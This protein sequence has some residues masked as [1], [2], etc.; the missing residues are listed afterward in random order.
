MTVDYVCGIRNACIAKIDL[1]EDKTIFS[2]PLDSKDINGG[3]DFEETIAYCRIDKRGW[4]CG[5]VTET[6]IQPSFGPTITKE[7]DRNE[8]PISDEEL[9]KI[10]ESDNDKM[11]AFNKFVAQLIKDRIV[12][13]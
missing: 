1:I 2:T 8:A 5:K 9:V 11:N 12:Q 13:E 10:L 4:V 3:L 6:T 7:R